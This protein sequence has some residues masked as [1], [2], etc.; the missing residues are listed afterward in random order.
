MNKEKICINTN[1]STI[2]IKDNCFDIIRIF[3]TFTVFLG[4]FL[5]HFDVDNK[6]LYGMAYFIRGVPVFFFLSGLFIAASLEKYNTKDFFWHRCIRI[7][8]EL[9]VCVLINLIII[10]FVM[11]GKYNV[12]DIVV[13]LITQLT[14]FQFYT[15]D[16]LREYGVGVPNGALWTITVDIQF[17]I[18]AVLLAKFLKKQRISIWGIVIVLSV[19][20]DWMLGWASERF[21]EIISKLIRCNLLP[22]IWI[23]LIGMCVYYH[24]Y[25]VIPFFVKYKWGFALGYILWT[26]CVPINIV[27]FFEGIRYN[28]V[29]TL[30]MVSFA[31]GIG[32]SYKCRMSQDYSYS[33]YL[34]HM[35]VINFIIHNIY[36]KFDSTIQFI[37]TFITTIMVIGV[38]SVLSHRY[39][40]GSF[41]KRIENVIFRYRGEN[42]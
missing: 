2:D 39:V 3:C 8:P 18:A 22:Y 42:E 32:F 1:N 19:I 4:H 26:Y 24:R 37:Y 16:W 7:F 33:F 28:I 29:T 13:Y 23:F 10:L 21:P 27:S 30:I 40:S 6:V 36:D 34:Y 17:Y 25:T 12:K 5:T 20:I 11:Q 41:S 31:I 14:V 38:C 15:G 35:V 9:W